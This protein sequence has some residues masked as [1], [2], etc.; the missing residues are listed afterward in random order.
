LV[1]FAWISINVIVKVGD[2][3]AIIHEQSKNIENE[4]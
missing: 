4:F 3:L 2:K 1:K